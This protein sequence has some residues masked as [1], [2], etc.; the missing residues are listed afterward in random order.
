MRRLTLTALC[1]L[2]A[3]AASTQAGGIISPSTTATPSPIASIGTA[4]ASPAATVTPFPTNSVRPSPTPTYT[5]SRT[6]VESDSGATINLKVGEVVNVSL[7]SEYDPPNSQ[8]AV[9]T[10]EGSTGGYPS[11]KPLAATFRAQEVGRTDIM[12]TTDYACLHAQPMCGIAQREWI[13]HVVV[14]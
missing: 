13:V 9:V 2:C 5:G 1:L 4:S 11:G 3:C 7:P 6:L 8:A 12:S 14:R 10:R